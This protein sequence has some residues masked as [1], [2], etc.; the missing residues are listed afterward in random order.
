MEL[1]EATGSKICW[2][3]DEKSA[4]EIS[5]DESDTLV[6]SSGLKD[7]LYEEILMELIEASSRR[8][9][10]AS[11]TTIDDSCENVSTQGNKT[12][13]IG[14]VV[15]VFDKKGGGN[16]LDETPSYL[17]YWLNTSMRTSVEYS[18]NLDVNK[19]F[20]NPDEVVQPAMDADCNVNATT[21]SKMSNNETCRAPYVQGNVSIATKWYKN[22]DTDQAQSTSSSPTYGADSHPSRRH[23]RS[24]SL[25]L[26]YLTKLEN[27]VKGPVRASARTSRVSSNDTGY[28]SGPSSPRIAFDDYITYRSCSSFMR[29]LSSS[30]VFFFDSNAEGGSKG[31]LTGSQ[32]SRPSSVVSEKQSNEE[33]VED[34][35]EEMKDDDEV[36]KQED[37]E[38]IK[39]EEDEVKMNAEEM[40]DELS[41]EDSCAEEDIEDATETCKKTLKMRG[42]KEEN[43]CDKNKRKKPSNANQ[44]RRSMK[45]PKMYIFLLEI[46]QTPNQHPCVKWQNEELKIFKIHD[47]QGLAKLWGVKKKKPNMRYENFARTLRGYISRGLLNK[48]RKKLVYQ[49][50]N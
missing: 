7:E 21:Q 23:Y 39:Q 20:S 45:M 48:P 22:L 6:L 4:E 12:C 47:S 43:K 46:L 18:Q 17:S 34:D 19:K 8:T 29:R 25:Q 24:S 42:D 41:E 38:V 10:L 15:D 27:A 2:F 37:D 33:K 26:P 30:S 3:I 16:D 14:S 36:I 44:K 35:D 31:S 49:F 40:D 13:G 11:F 28:M 5:E 50:A 32:T 1:D 9:S